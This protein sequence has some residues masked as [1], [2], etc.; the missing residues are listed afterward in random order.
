MSD[1]EAIANLRVQEY[2]DD[3]SNLNLS[4][5][6]SQW[7]NVDVATLLV[8]CKVVGHDIDEA[9]GASLIFLEKSVLMCCC[10]SG[11]MHHYPKHLLHC[12]VDDKRDSHDNPDGIIFKAELF[13][14]SPSEEQLCWEEVCHSEIQ[15]PSVQ[16]KVSRW[17]SWLNS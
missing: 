17:L 16:N 8:N 10:N 4:T 15:V 12:F 6:E 1:D 9:T 14:I 2:L 3:V 5:S 13:S 7:Y 11:K